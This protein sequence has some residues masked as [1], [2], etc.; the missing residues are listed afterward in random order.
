MSNTRERFFRKGFV[1]YV[2]L[3]LLPLLL[4][5]LLGQMLT[6]RSVTQET[7][8]QERSML[9]QLETIMNYIQEEMDTFVLALDQE[10][11]F[12]SVSDILRQEE[13][14]Y[15]RSRSLSLLKDWIMSLVNMRD[16]IDSIYIYIENG[17][18]RMMHADDGVRLIATSADQDWLTIFRDRRG[19]LTDW[20]MRRPSCSAAPTSTATLSRTSS[21]A[22]SAR[23][24]WKS[25]SRTRTTS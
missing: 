7:A 16:Y 6:I 8:A 2:R 17:N 3:I 12:R 13:L 1:R 23:I 20:T 4:C 18:D 14:N 15:D 11:V 24:T 19:S 25:S 9:R 22:T 10:S 21:P 5:T